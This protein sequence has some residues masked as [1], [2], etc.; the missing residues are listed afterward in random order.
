MMLTRILPL[1]LL[2][3]VTFSCV[4]DSDIKTASD[5]TI[6]LTGWDFTTDGIAGLDGEWTIYPQQFLTPEDLNNPDITKNKEIINV[7]GF[8]PWKRSITHATLTLKIQLNSGNQPLAIRLGDIVSAYKLWINGEAAVEVGKIS[9][10]RSSEKYDIS[11]RIIPIKSLEE[12]IFLV[13]Q[14]SNFHNC[15]GGIADR[16]Y[17]GSERDI[18][19]QYDRQ[20]GFGILLSGCFL[21]IGFYH[22]SICLIRLKD[23]TTLYFGLICIEIGILCLTSNIT[24]HFLSKLIPVID[25]LNIYRLD[26][27]VTHSASFIGILYFSNLFPMDS[28]KYFPG[29]YLVQTVICSF[30]VIFFPVHI[31]SWTLYLFFIFALLALVYIFL[32]SIKA[33]RNRREGAILFTAGYVFFAV[34]AVNDILYGNR[35]LQTG[36]ILH[37]GMLGLI[38]S[39]SFLLA[40]K[41]Y[42]AFTAEEALSKELAQKNIALS[43]LDSIKDEFLANTSHE[44]RTPLHGIIGIA[45][46][47][48]EGAAGK[49]SDEIKNNLALIVSSGSRLSRLVND[50]LDFSRLKNR[51]ISLIKRKVDI[52]ALSE[53][54]V[55]SLEKQAKK[56]NIKIIPDLP[57]SIPYILGDEDRIQQIL[58]NIMGNAVKYTEKGSIK[59]SAEAENSIVRVS[60]QDTGKGIPELMQQKIFEPFERINDAGTELQQGTGIGLAVTKKLI[61]LHGGEID[62][63]SKEGEGSLFYFTIPVWEGETEQEETL[64]SDRL[65]EDVN[66]EESTNV[67]TTIAD[68]QEFAEYEIEHPWVLVVDDDPVN[69]RVVANHLATES[70][71]FATLTSGQEALDFFEKGGSA[72]LVLLDIMMPGLTGIDVCEKLRSKYQPAELPVIMLTARNRVSDFIR[73]YKYGAS[74]YLTKPFTREELIVRVKFHLRLKEAYKSLHENLRL[75]MELFEQKLRE[76]KALILAEKATLEMLRYQL[77]PHFLFNSLASIRGAVV[78]DPYMARDMITNLAEFCRLILSRKGK[79]MTPVKEEADLIKLYLDIEK[80]RLGDYLTVTI[81]IDPQLTEIEIPSF[82]LQPLVENAVKYGRQTSPEKLD[83]TISVGYDID[84]NMFLEVANTGAWMEPEQRKETNSTGIGLDNL[85]QRIE[86][87]YQGEAAVATLN[88]E[89]WV[90]VRLIIPIDKEKA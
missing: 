17:L 29:I 3:F 82:I 20:V 25:S 76:E 41:F 89:D 35:I 66:I 68:I 44:L 26:M 2:I 32:F 84:E 70:I 52:K 50:I 22:V 36:F 78:K 24:D 45:E 40:F 43:K 79:D 87:I 75:Q 37:I 86:K 12:Y 7:P 74:D 46:S 8:F 19:S 85:K 48:R 57:G 9:S 23:R 55:K 58:F 62:V 60:V 51:D 6:D 90:R 61:E 18:N 33:I 30:T 63:D 1:L 67:Q 31:S 5:G 88:E 13:L 27:L 15:D 73:A 28:S 21:M 83:I 53:L 64:L 39:H 72:D 10:S 34:T 4:S 38:L 54:V 11:G 59:I 65:L 16:I 71:P 81:E 49:I 69:L 77:N 80:V 56:K 47:L 42:K 14:I